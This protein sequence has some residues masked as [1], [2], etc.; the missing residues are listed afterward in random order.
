MDIEAAVPQAE[1]RQ[2]LGT[3]PRSEGNLLSSWSVQFTEVEI[4][5]SPHGVDPL[6]CS[7]NPA[8]SGH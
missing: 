7:E 4:G 2:E 3:I 1:A 6:L 8:S 5:F